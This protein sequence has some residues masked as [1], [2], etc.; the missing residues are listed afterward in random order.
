MDV[1]ST[2]CTVEAG[3]AAGV[4]A[5]FLII[6]VV[7]IVGVAFGVAIRRKEQGRNRGAAQRM[8]ISQQSRA[9]G[10]TQEVEATE[11]EEENTKDRPNDSVHVESSNER[12]EALYQGLDVGTQDYESM[13]TQLRG[14]T[15]QELDPRGRE[16][17]H[18]DQ[19]VKQ[20]E[21]EACK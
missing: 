16:E 21:G 13:Y 7:F 17:E 2:P 14:G 11:E 19:R 1:S 18:H 8:G 5:A 9:I 20:G 15:D 12:R 4:V 3:I 10:T 6:L